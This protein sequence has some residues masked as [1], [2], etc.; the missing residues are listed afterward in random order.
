MNRNMDPLILGLSDARQA[1]LGL[2]SLDACSVF[3]LNLHD[4]KNDISYANNATSPLVIDRISA[5]E[6][7]KRHISKAFERIKM[8]N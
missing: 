1:R 6:R 7:H 4:K 5:G 2:D 3:S 8:N